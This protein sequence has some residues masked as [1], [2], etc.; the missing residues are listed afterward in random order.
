MSEF[1]D[2]TRWDS[3]LLLGAENALR[4]LYNFYMAIARGTI[5]GLPT[6]MRELLLVFF[7]KGEG[8]GDGEGNIVRDCV[9]TRPL[10]MANTDAKLLSSLRCIPLNQVSSTIVDPLQKCVRQMLELHFESRRF[11]CT[12]QQVRDKGFVPIFNV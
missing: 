3:I 5:V 4:Y 1:F 6:D 2:G 8:Q 12:L 10:S 9:C 7:P 11:P